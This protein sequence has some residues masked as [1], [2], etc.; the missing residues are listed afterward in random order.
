MCARCRRTEQTRSPSALKHDEILSARERHPL[1]RV[2]QAAAGVLKRRQTSPL[3]SEAWR[4]FMTIA[5]K[6]SDV[7]A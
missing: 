2:A 3:D 7:A 5:T 4:A 6:E 1:S